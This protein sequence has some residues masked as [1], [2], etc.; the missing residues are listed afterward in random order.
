MRSVILNSLRV[1]VC[2]VVL[3]IED[4]GDNNFGRDIFAVLV[5]VMRI[6][7]CRIALRKSSRIAETSRIEERMR[8]VDARIDVPNLDPRAGHGSATRSVHAPDALIT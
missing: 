4:F 7:V 1:E 3:I 8:V 6:A 2:L 5:L